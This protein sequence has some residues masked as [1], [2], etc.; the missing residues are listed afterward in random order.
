MLILGLLVPR[1]STVY[2]LMMHSKCAIGNVA[3]IT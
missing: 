3:K 2:Y 1:Y